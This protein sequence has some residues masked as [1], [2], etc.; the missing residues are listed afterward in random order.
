MVL[1]LCMGCI[2]CKLGY[3]PNRPINQSDE[4]VFLLL[5]NRCNGCHINAEDE[6]A[7]IFLLEHLDHYKITVNDQVFQ[8]R[9]MPKG[10]ELTEYEMELLRVWIGNP[11][12]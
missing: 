5:E 11:L 7:P 4:N 8:K 6:G 3:D 9:A 10:T 1:I 12:K 2:T